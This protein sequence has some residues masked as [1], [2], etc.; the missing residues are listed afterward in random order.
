MHPASAGSKRD[1]AA[2]S[3]WTEPPGPPQLQPTSSSIPWGSMQQECP[4]SDCLSPS[5]WA[6]GAMS[7]FLSPEQELVTPTIKRRPGRSPRDL[8]FLQETDWLGGSYQRNK[9][10]AFLT[11]LNHFFF[12]FWSAQTVRTRDTISRSITLQG[13]LLAWSTVYTKFFSQA[14]YNKYF[15]SY[16][17]EIL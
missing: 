8:G 13:D 4:E 17:G 5:P 9:M 14:I 15:S 3:G 1:Q 2:L 7:S 12:S 10:K 11:I 16:A 6:H